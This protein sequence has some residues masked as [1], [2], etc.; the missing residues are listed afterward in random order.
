MF[1]RV[2]FTEYHAPMQ[3][4]FSCDYR[5]IDTFII[6]IAKRYQMVTLQEYLE[7]HR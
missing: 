6:I 4:T 7:C 5:I 3:C 2:V 1:Y